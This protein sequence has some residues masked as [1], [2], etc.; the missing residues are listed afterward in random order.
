[1]LP[2]MSNL[3]KTKKNKTKGITT[4]TRTPITL[5]V[6]FFKVHL[7]KLSLKTIYFFKKNTKNVFPKNGI[8][9]S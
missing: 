6:P 5:D 8:Y 4:N 1:M 3:T 2:F 7:S 9:F